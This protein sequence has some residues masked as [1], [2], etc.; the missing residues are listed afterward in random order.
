MTSAWLPKTSTTFS[1]DTRR[2]PLADLQAG[3]VAGIV[4]MPLAV[5]LAIASGVSPG[6]RRVAAVVAGIP[7]PGIQ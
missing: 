1:G 6:K 7:I 2:Q 5:A 3:V 4:A